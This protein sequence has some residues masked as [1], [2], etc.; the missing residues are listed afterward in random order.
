MT[1]IPH[2]FAI[3]AVAALGLTACDD[4]KAATPSTPETM[5]EEPKAEAPKPAA[6]Q[7]SAPKPPKPVV[8]TD[9]VINEAPSAAPAP[10]PPKPAA[11]APAP[12]N[13]P[14]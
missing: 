13:P 2:L 6:L 1:K 8:T 5:K 7:P 12:T 9:E 3:A 11:P 14:N 10:P 4:K